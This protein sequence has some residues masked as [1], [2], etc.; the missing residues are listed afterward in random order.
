MAAALPPGANLLTDF[1]GPRSLWRR[2]RLWCDVGVE[3][4][5]LTSVDPQ[6]EVQVQSSVVVAVLGAVQG[7]VRA[8]V[9]QLLLLVGPGEAERS[10]VLSL[11]IG[12]SLSLSL[13]S[14]EKSSI[15][16]KKAYL[17]LR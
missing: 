2:R 6:V 9:V 14:F 5:L 11:V 7:A 10:K 3:A 16:L 12:A 8:V 4:R 17:Q 13:L 15:H 1:T